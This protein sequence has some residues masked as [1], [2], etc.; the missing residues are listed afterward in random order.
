MKDKNKHG[1]AALQPRTCALALGLLTA[2]TLMHCGNDEGRSASPDSPTAPPAGPL[3]I[4]FW[5]PQHA[6][7]L[8]IWLLLAAPNAS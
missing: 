7:W 6:C 5:S 4:Y 1:L 3:P 2:L 8:G